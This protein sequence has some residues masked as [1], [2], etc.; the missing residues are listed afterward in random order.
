MRIKRNPYNLLFL[1]AILLFLFG[2]LNFR[3]VIDIHLHDTFYVV[4]VKHLLWALAVLLFLL[5]LLYF[6]TKKYLYSKLLT[7]IHVIA[8]IVTSIFILSIP[9][10]LKDPYRELAGM[11]RRYYDVGESNAYQFAGELSRTALVCAYILAAGQLTY[12][13]N[14]I[15]G[16]FKHFA[17]QKSDN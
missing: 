2:F 6:I 5:W 12:L 8:T 7:W 1:L 9:F 4:T 17:S 10:L 3:S 14:L 15:W 13:L 11:P 16:L